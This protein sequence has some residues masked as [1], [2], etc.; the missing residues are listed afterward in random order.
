MWN[1]IHEKNREIKNIRKIYPLKQGVVGDIVRA[2]D[3]Y[4]AIDKVI[5]FG[6]SVTSLCN[7]W[8]AVDIYFENCIG[9]PWGLREHIS[10]EYALQSLDVWTNEMVD[11]TLLREIETKG[12]IVYER[13]K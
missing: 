3:G 2:V 5:V 8:S 1:L 7:P 13:Q 12:V 9:Y 10:K 4:T 11:E 6:S